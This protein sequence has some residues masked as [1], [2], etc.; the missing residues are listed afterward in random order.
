MGVTLLLVQEASGRIRGALGTEQCEVRAEWGTLVLLEVSFRFMYFELAPLPQFHISQVPH[1]S[2]FQA[3]LMK[4]GPSL[5]ISPK[6]GE[7]EGSELFWA[8][9]LGGR[10]RALG[11]VADMGFAWHM[12][13][14]FSLAARFFSFKEN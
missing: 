2:P 11:S 9:L 10:M 6:Q 13:L 4:P 3:G 1:F 7:W 12:L 8:L 14:L 5:P